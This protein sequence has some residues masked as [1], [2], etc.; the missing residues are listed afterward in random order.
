VGK[1]GCIKKAVDD[2]GIAGRTTFEVVV[3]V[4]VVVL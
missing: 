2:F 4:V 3:V 1:R